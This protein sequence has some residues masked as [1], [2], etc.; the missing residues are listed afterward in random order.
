MTVELLNKQN[1]RTTLGVLSKGWYQIN[2]QIYLI[3]GNSQNLNGSGVGYEPFSE[4][5]SYKLGKLLG[6]DCVKYDLKSANQFPEITT[7]GCDVVSVCKK[8]NL[9]PTQQ[10]IHFAEYADLVNGKEVSDYFNFYL[11]SELPNDYLIK[12][13]VFDAITGNSDRHLNNFDVVFDG[14]TITMAPVLDNGAAMFGTITD[15]QLKPFKGIGPDKSKPFK[16]THTLQIKLL[17]KRF[18]NT[19]CFCVNKESV[20]TEWKRDCA[21]IFEQLPENRA[22][23][24]QEYVKR[25]LCF[26]D[27]FNEERKIYAV[28]AF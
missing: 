3:K 11:H 7:Y 25:R 12:L 21:E 20:Y 1:T 22:I 17:Q 14:R 6:V 24:I 19:K 10:L 15:S 8:I 27:Y 23:L 28:N 18:P 4:V 26:L 9:S 16:E 5:L 13:L 2:G